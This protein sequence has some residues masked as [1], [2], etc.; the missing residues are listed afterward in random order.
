MTLHI[1]CACILNVTHQTK[2][3]TKFSTMMSSDQSFARLD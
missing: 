1:K 2:T 3:G